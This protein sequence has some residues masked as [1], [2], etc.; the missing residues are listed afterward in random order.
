MGGIKRRGGGLTR[1]NP[2]SEEV[3]RDKSDL[4]EQL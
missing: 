3:S 1:E 4:S 2:R